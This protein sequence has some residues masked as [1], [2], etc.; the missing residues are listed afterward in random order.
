MSVLF[1]FIEIEQ[2]LFPVCDY[3][4]LHLVVKSFSIAV[5]H[6]TIEVLLQTVERYNIVHVE[7]KKK[8]LY[9]N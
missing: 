7:I 8:S 2:C 6:I 3:I 5:F 1:S 9:V 4:V